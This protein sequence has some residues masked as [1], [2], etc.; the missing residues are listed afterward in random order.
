MSR[1]PWERVLGERA[2]E[3]DP[4]LQAYFG[5]IP[6]GMVGRGEGV[7][8][9][10]GTPRRWLWPV[11]ELLAL[12]GI[13]YPAW[14]HDVPF[15]VTNRASDRG[16]VFAKRLFDFGD[17]GWIM[18]DEIGITSAGLT[19]RVGRN[20]HIAVTFEASVQDGGLVLRSTGVT[21][22]LGRVRIP[23]GVVAP[24]VTLVERI[25]GERQSVAL[26]MRLPVIGTIYEYSGSFSYAIEP[27][28]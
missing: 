18:T 20:G 9:V 14:A 24:R 1:S 23:L 19:D 4:A 28:D 17:N 2:R 13:V 25:S 15:T 21:L 5:A 12:D 22:R 26:Q 16:T 11:L 10:V 27:E 3:L 8:D 6:P 7:F